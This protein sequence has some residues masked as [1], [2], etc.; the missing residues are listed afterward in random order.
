MI[1]YELLLH[2]PSCAGRA[3]VLALPTQ[4]PCT[5]VPPYPRG[6]HDGLTTFT[7]TTRSTIHDTYFSPHQRGVPLTPKTLSRSISSSFSQRLPQRTREDPWPPP[8]SPAAPPSWTAGRR[9]A[10]PCAPSLGT[11]APPLPTSL[12]PV[13]ATG[14]PFSTQCFLVFLR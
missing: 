3:C 7:S 12:V 1:D 9:C 14:T 2:L 11:C 13:P 8:P 5:R 4:E 6:A 10:P